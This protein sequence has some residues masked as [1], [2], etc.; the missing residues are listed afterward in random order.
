MKNMCKDN[1]FSEMEVKISSF[2]PLFIYMQELLLF[3]Y[4]I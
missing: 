3:L 1:L 4:I 2:L